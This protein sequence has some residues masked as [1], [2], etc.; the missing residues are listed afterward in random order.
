MSSRKKSDVLDAVSVV[1]VLDAPQVVPNERPGKE[2]GKRDLNRRERTRTIMTAA[3]RQFLVRGVDGVT[4]DEIAQGAG[5]AKGSFYRYFADRVGL[6]E[7]IYAPLRDALVTAVNRCEAELLA[8]ER[9]EEVTAAWLGLGLKLAPVLLE[10]PE[11]ARLYL[12]E[13]RGP[14]V[15]A[16]VPIRKLA[17]E[18]AE[19]ALRLTHAARSRRLL[20]DLDPGVTSL[21]VIGAVE[22]LLLAT[23]DGTLSVKDPLT[24][25]ETLV[26]LVLDGLRPP[27][28]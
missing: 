8:A 25:T 1:P 27:A 4:V 10:H 20:R 6:V 26:S 22:R 5:I 13:C 18:V 23:M 15:G 3:I 9:L 14:A 19:S 21:S 2:G 12:Q 17:D 24:V 11:V 7:A 16:R 28:R